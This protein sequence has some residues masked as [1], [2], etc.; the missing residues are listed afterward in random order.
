[1]FDNDTQLMVSIFR[2]VFQLVGSEERH[3][4][5][6]VKTYK[7]DIEKAGQLFAYLGLAKLDTQ[8]PLGWRP[9]HALLDVIAKRA[10]RRSKPIERTVYAE[11]SLIICLLLD[12]AFGEDREDYPLCAFEVLNALGLTR[13]STE[14][15]G[16]IPTRHL[17]QL[18]AEA[19]DDRQAKK[20]KPATS[21][22]GA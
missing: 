5:R 7:S 16:E 13:T 4:V 9:T 11:D 6:Y 18:F 10:V 3:P 14:D 17:Q 12:A 22:W 20:V 15:N 1:M 21:D 8:S 19:Y 2:R